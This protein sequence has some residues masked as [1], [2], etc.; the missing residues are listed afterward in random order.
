MRGFACLIRTAILDSLAPEVPLRRTCDA[1][2]V[3]EESKQLKHR[4]LHT[5]HG[6]ET[7]ITTTSPRITVTTG[8]ANE[9]QGRFAR[10]ALRSQRR[11][12]LD[13]FRGFGDETWAAPTRCTEWSVH[14]VVR[15]LCDVTLKSTALLRGATPESVGTEDVDPRTTP[16]TWLTR[17]AGE[18]PH[19][20]LVVFEDAS[21]E[22]LAEVDRHIRDA[23]DAEVPWLYGQVPWSIAV[24]HV[25][26]DAWVHERDILLPLRRPHESP[27]VESRAAATYGLTMGCLPALVAGTPLDETVVLAGD[28]GGVF[29]LEARNGGPN[30]R[31]L[32][33]AATALPGEVTITTRDSDVGGRRRRAP[34]GV[35][36]VV[37]SLVGRGPELTEVLR[38]PPERVQRLGMLRAFMLLPVS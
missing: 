2:G 6:V 12:L 35:L 14:E 8:F 22:L 20:T 19:D 5:D 7:G 37:D 27:A 24:L 15:H 38:G 29:Q 1:H 16:A 3:V 30:A 26:W 32:T 33:M 18:R 21:A 13:L 34:R 9:A 23:S 17:S 4:Q 25:F 36:D 31:E 10:D 28:G 11:R